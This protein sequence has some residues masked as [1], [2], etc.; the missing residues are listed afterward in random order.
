M[1]ESVA[2]VSRSGGDSSA[3]VGRFVAIVLLSD[4]EW[5]VYPAMSVLRSGGRSLDS[6][7]GVFHEA[8]RVTVSPIGRFQCFCVT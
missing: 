2:P 8:R 7:G 3:L 5:G 6:M 4:D 1:A